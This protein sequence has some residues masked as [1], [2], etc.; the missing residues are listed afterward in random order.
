MAAI[1]EIGANIYRINVEMPGK[2]VT[3]SLFLID[4]EQPTLVETSYRRV[5]AEVLDAVRTILDPATIRHIVI[6]HFEGDEC[7]GLNLFLEA[8]PH[9]QP[10]CSPTGAATS[11]PD[12]AIRE[13]LRVDETAVLDLGAHKLSFLLTPY[14]HAW[15]SVLAYDETTRT[16][17]SS[18]LFLQPG[19]GPAVTER[20]MSEEMID[21]TRSIGLFPSQAHL[22]AALDKID[23]FQPET[24]ACHHGTVKA[25]H[26]A[27]HLA[28]FRHHDV[29]GLIP[30]DTVHTSIVTPVSDGLPTAS[31]TD[32]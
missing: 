22:V 14:V 23:L 18:D 16:L 17:F 32:S 15:D 11:I 8:A 2:P 25:G 30:T 4:D 27:T 19:R 21:Y 3:F 29:T 10:V 5:F 12:F 1:A 9:A 26:I 13:P 24:L 20:D 31:N 6:P 28:A 7:G